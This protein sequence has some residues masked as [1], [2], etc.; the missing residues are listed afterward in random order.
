MTGGLFFDGV[1]WRLTGVGSFFRRPLFLIAIIN[2]SMTRD[3]LVKSLIAAANDS[4]RRRLF[5][6][7]ARLADESLAD[8]IRLA[9]Y[10]A[11]TVE[12]IKA[13]RAAAALKVFLR[14]NPAPEIA[15]ASAWVTGIANITRGS[16]EAADAALAAAYDGLTRLGRKADAAQTQVARL[17]PLAMLGRYDEA[18][19]VGRKALK[20]LIA[21]GDQLAA[22]KIE[23]NLSNIV[24]RRAQ[25]HEAERYC[26]S[27]RRRFIAAGEKSWQA[28]AENGLGNTYTE[29]NEFRKA[30]VYYK[31]ALAG[32]LSERMFVT[33]AEIEASLGNLA[34]LRGRYGVALRYL[35]LSRQKYDVLG[36][37]HQS[38]VADLEIADIY[39]ELNLSAEAADIYGRVSSIFKRL[40]LRGEEARARLG[41][42][43]ALA[44][45]DRPAAARAQLK[46]ASRLFGLE[47]N[48]SGH[49]SAMLAQASLAIEQGSPA[50][51]GELLQEVSRAI[52]ADENPRHQVRLRLSKGAAFLAAGKY[53]LATPEFRAAHDLARRHQHIDSIHSALNSLGEICLRKGNETE[54]AKYFKKAVA[55][56]EDQRSPLG[57]GEFSMAFFASR[58]KPFENLAGLLLRQNRTRSAFN[59]IERGR[60]QS[61]LDLLERKTLTGDA[62]PRLQNQLAELRSELNFY[63]KRLDSASGEATADLTTAIDRS[64]AAVAGILRRINSLSAVSSAEKVLTRRRNAAHELQKRLGPSRTLIEYVITGGSISAF[65]VTAGKV[66]F[67]K[68]VGTI[69]IVE[70]LLSDLHFQFGAVRYGS[71]QVSRFADQMRHRADVCLGRLYDQLLRGLAGRLRGKHLVIV[72]AGPLHYVPFHALHDGAGYVIENYQTSYAPSASVWARLQERPA[73]KIRNSLLVAFA[74]ERIPLVEDEVREI[75]RDVPRPKVLTGNSAT[76][77]AFTH[78]AGRHDL[79]HLACHGQFRPD[80]PM[81]SNLHLADGWVT[82]QDITSQRLRAGLVTLSACETGLSRIFAGDEIL[83]LAR[84]FLAAGAASLIVSLWNVNDEATGKLMKDLYFNLQRGASISASLSDAQLAFVRRGEHPFLWSPFI[85]IGC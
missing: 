11:W 73:K 49:V 76:F 72:P 4:E 81:F 63:Y 19:A 51:A 64:E 15:A 75:K 25:H 6:E 24:S 37:P 74:D 9:I 33:E 21:E 34:L 1:I 60:S 32:A 45:L 40:K 26:L 50:K 54:A 20:V 5:V 42:G 68:D 79:I 29:L 10:T 44:R 56:I 39:A 58:L 41:N 30:E 43:E 7:N 2:G 28:M 77:A 17:L 46:A 82:V 14:L 36:M 66:D 80:N 35:E 57:A 52:K 78:E 13:Q 31:K 59:A 27:A 18:V 71:A 67:I 70:G 48:H 85:L 23:M 84:G 12:P 53:D 69:S 47:G 62:P 65:V 22:G 3:K 55:I 8:R 61:L 83:G 38:A 16:F